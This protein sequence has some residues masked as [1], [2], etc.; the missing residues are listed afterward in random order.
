MTNSTIMSNQERRRIALIHGD[1]IGKESVPVAVD[2]LRRDVGPGIVLEFVDSPWSCD[3]HLELGPMVP[4]DALKITSPVDAIFPGAVGG[5]PCPGPYL[6]LGSRDY[7]TTRNPGAQ[8][9]VPASLGVRSKRG[10]AQPSVIAREAAQSPPSRF[11][12]DGR[13]GWASAQSST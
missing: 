7:R 10:N 8:A 4:E 11:P 12:R 9:G 1:R 3:H 5:P 6:D 2:L 13:G